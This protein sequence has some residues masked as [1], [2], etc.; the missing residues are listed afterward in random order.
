MIIENNFFIDTHLFFKKVSKKFILPNIGKL[1]KID[2]SDKPDLSK[3]TKFD[4][5]VENELIEYFN[6]CNFNNI[7]SE[8]N[9]SNLLK[10][11]SYLTIDPID[12]TRN[13]INGINKV[14]IMVSYIENESSIFSIIY[15]PVEDLFYHTHNNLIYKNF[16][17][18]KYSRY[19]KHIGFLGDHAKIYFKDYVS[20][21]IEKKRSRSIGYDVL[22][23]L[24]GKRS[25]MTIYGSK[26]WDLF[27]AMSF[28]KILNFKT[29]LPN[30]NFDYT[31]LDEK[32]IFYA[33]L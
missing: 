5:L 13:F 23:V 2:I 18:I 30:M 19:E 20:N 32:I 6:K 10:E 8:E 11:N 16:I 21:P 3:V 12:G 31:K 24:E 7:I 14:V 1:N 28:L 33:E 27:P 26:I 25:F 4:L 22:E 17:E 15:D 29:N 9:S